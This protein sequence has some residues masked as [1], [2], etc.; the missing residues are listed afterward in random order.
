V[1]DT[2]GVLALGGRQPELLGVVPE[3]GVRGDE[4][5]VE[6]IARHLR[7][8]VLQDAGAL[9]RRLDDAELP[10]RVVV[11]EQLRPPQ[12]DVVRTPAGAAPELVLDDVGEG[13]REDLAADERTVVGKARREV[14][15]EPIVGALREVQDE[16]R[17]QQG[18]D[19]QDRDDAPEQSQ[20]A[21]TPP[22]TARPRPCRRRR[23]W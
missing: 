4:I 13:G 22:R 2:L 14:E 5:R 6:G 3:G 8:M 11:G 7:Q 10:V 18:G 21:A 15:L 20:R 9:A 16:R 23:T 12:D 1:P 19:D 17:S